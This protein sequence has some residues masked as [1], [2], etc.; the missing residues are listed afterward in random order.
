M[1][2]AIGKKDC[3]DWCGGSLKMDLNHSLLVTLTIRSEVLVPHSQNEQG[4]F[5]GSVCL[6]EYL[7]DYLDSNRANRKLL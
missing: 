2:G 3:C 7:D 1:T 5:C 4:T 6:Q